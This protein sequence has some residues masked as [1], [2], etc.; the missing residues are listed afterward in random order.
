MIAQSNELIPY[1]S[2]A[3]MA[4]AYQ[5]AIAK[6]AQAK[7]LIEEACDQLNDAFQVKDKSTYSAEL[8]G[9]RV[10]SGAS[11]YDGNDENVAAFWKLQAW[12][13]LVHRLGITK[14]MS[15][16][17]RNEFEAAVARGCSD[18]KARSEALPDIT[19]D[20]IYSVLMGYC[21]SA[22]EFLSE[23]ITEE[24]D[25][26]KC[27]T[28][29]AKL[30]TQR[31]NVAKLDRKVIRGFMVERWSSGWHVN[32]RTESHL[33]AIDNIFHLL[34]GRGCVNAGTRGPLVDAILASDGKGET[35]YFRFKCFQNRNLHL[36]FKRLDLL[37]RFNQICGRN[38]LA[39]ER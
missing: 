2:A 9:A 5:S 22:E 29:T 38:R 24:Y 34:D 25:F 4:Q 18:L 39:D 17:R 15:T 37:E 3:N 8:F 19:P 10:T 20:S 7:L 13:T 12:R 31:N 33:I 6:V 28:M 30:K 1:S 11:S 23:A 35:D 27:H 16:K 36:E 21:S 14:T 32:H 26:W